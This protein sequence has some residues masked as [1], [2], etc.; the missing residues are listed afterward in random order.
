MAFS[1]NLK[2][3]KQ[4][5]VIILTNTSANICVFFPWFFFQNVQVINVTELW[6]NRTTRVPKSVLRY[7]SD[8]GQYFGLEISLHPLLFPNKKTVTYHGVK[9]FM[10]WMYPLLI[11]FLR[12]ILT[13][14]TAWNTGETG[15][16]NIFVALLEGC[17]LLSSQGTKN[18]ESKGLNFFMMSF[19]PSTYQADQWTN[20]DN[21]IIFPPTQL[22]L[23]SWA[24]TH[25]KWYNT[26]VNNFQRERE[27]ERDR[28]KIMRPCPYFL[29]RSWEI[30]N[31]PFWQKFA[32]HI[33][34][35]NSR[36]IDIGSVKISPNLYYLILFL[37]FVK[38]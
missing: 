20:L 16:I 15:D 27:R 29:P 34:V 28:K 19:S 22:I 33:W 21:K 35:G 23:S 17:M 9:L 6:V 5:A 30:S 3:K 2:G 7:L 38:R 14:T 11:E 25:E 32:N 31:V 4:L 36:R 1:K 10:E 12:P 8:K 26:I 37:I 18:K 13:M 24:L